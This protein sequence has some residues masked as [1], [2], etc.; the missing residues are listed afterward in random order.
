MYQKRWLTGPCP[1]A[2][3]SLSVSSDRDLVE[4]REEKDKKLSRTS[5]R[6]TRDGKQERKKEDRKGKKRKIEF[7]HF[8]FYNLTANDDD[9]GDDNNNRHFLLSC[10][11][12]V[13]HLCNSTEMTRFMVAFFPHSAYWLWC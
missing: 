6:E 5:G 7:R 1:D 2:L 10:S 9:D 12:R 11:G 13:L 4:V 8:L 3:R